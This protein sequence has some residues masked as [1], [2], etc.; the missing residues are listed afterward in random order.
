MQP[1]MYS[2]RLLMTVKTT[3]PSASRS[4]LVFLFVFLFL[5]LFSNPFMSVVFAQQSSSTAQPTPDSSAPAP[6]AP[7]PTQKETVIVTGTF[8]PAPLSENDRSV[9]LFDAR[10]NSLL[11]ASGVDY[12]RYDPAVD[13][14]QRAPDGVQVDLTILGSTFAET[15]VLVN[16]QRMDDAQTSHH[17]MDIPLSP[18]AVSRI[19]VLHG[20]GST[21]YGSDAMGG[22]VNFVTAPAE[23]SELRLRAGLGDDGFNQE[24]IFGSLLV[25]NWSETVAAD[26]DFS[27]GFISDRDFRS[28]VASSET[29]YKSSLGL[30]DVLI[31]GSDRPFGARDFYGDYPSWERTKNWFASAQQDLGE[32]TSAS[33]GY[34]RH[35][36]EYILVRDNPALYENNHIDQSWQAALRRHDSLGD[37]ST[38]SYGAETQGDSI[39]SNNLGEHARNREAL[40]ANL[41]FRALHRFSS[42]A[43]AREEVFSGGMAVFAPALAGGLW[44]TRD[45]KLRASGSRGFRLPTYTDLYYSDPSTIGN[46]LLKPESAWSFDAGADWTPAQRVSAGLTFF[47]RW[48]SDVIDYVQAAPGQP[49]QATNVQRLH[50]T[51]VEAQAQLHLPHEQHIQLAYT[52]LHGNQ[53][54][55]PGEVS[56]YVFNYPSHAG[57]FGWTGAWRD[58]LVARTRVGVTQ[59][60]EQEAYPVWDLAIARQAGVIRPYLQLT[61]LSNTGYEEIPG[62]LMPS[63]SIIAGME[64]VLTK[65]SH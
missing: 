35:S 47:Q 13:L 15:L 41:D 33:F 26:R 6:A 31:A 17:D 49:Y 40:Y 51:G 28:S 64:L 32:R 12:L 29:R 48:D 43:G 56:R 46:P 1:T 19:E 57:I 30:T 18:E 63:R 55:L 11:F 10:E 52:F 21:F 20:A 42:S 7:S 58:F 59:R 38:L 53:Q 44:L 22:A 3:A 37:N 2:E 25:K 65:K 27:T 9:V 62:V 60:F 39:E 8:I 5:V 34:R 54:P 4:L 24:H 61:N 23:A 45:L 50:F 14:Q 16:G 36:D